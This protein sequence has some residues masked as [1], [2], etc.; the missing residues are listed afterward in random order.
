MACYAS[1]LISIAKAEIG[2]LEKKS[3]YMLD[4]KTGNSGKNNYTKYGRDLI[5][6]KS[7]KPNPYALATPWCDMFVD[8]CFIKAFGTAKAKELLGGWSAY[9]PTSAQYLKN[10]GRYSGKP[11]IGDVVFFKNSRGICHTGIVYKVDNRKVYT[12]EGN[13]S[14]SSGVVAN[15]GC[16][17]DK[18]YPLGYAK[19]HGYGHP[20]YDKETGGT[21]N[22]AVKTAVAYPTYVKRFQTWLNKTYSAGA[23]L[24]GEYDE[25]TR[26][27]A[28]RAI[29][30]YL[31]STY[32]C[33][34]S[35]DGLFGTKT[36]A[37][38]KKYANIKKGAR[39]NLVYIL[40]GALYGLG[41]NPAG[42]DGSF[43]MGCNN[44][45]IKY[46]DANGLARDG[47][48]G[49]NTWESLLG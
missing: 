28:I 8:W 12:I 19:I 49:S 26:A 1:R 17:N 45:V 40:Q 7:I 34:L 38:C 36:K 2:Y 16:V 3:N 29:Q 23:V 11:A 42:F 25:K 35:V 30:K 33:K 4:S 31:N 48:V 14:S 18:S 43:G 39:G 46:Q 15:G 10:M 44:A 37:A 6:N 13:T 20:K 9:T 24:S 41:Y 27:A 22:T 47:V 32:R 21:A 5:N